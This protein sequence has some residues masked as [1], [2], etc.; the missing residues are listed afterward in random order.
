MGHI[1]E[2]ENFEEY[3]NASAEE[4]SKPEEEQT[5][6]E[7]EME[8]ERVDRWGAPIAEEATI[9]DKDRWGAEPIEP[10]KPD[11]DPQKKKSG[12]QWWIIA[13]VV[14]VVLCLC[15]CIAFVALPLLGFNLFQT[16]SFQF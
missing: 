6:P 10:A 16:S 8:D 5:Q 13:L 7:P 11:F 3:M 4:W 2:D 15:A 9:S 14:L 12:T 1:P